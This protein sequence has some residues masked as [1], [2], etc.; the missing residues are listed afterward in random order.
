MGTSDPARFPEFEAIRNISVL[1]G[2]KSAQGVSDVLSSVHAGILTSEFE[3]M[4][5]SVLETLGAG[6]PV[7]AVHLPQLESVIKDGTSG[8]LIARST[9]EDEMA[10][11]LAE[12]FVDIRAR[13]ASGAVTP[14]GVAAQVGDFTP[15]KQ[16]AKIY[17]N[18]RELQRR[19]YGA[20]GPT[21]FAA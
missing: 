1:H 19:R 3:G 17:E 5:F 7:C 12:A 10:V 11:R 9:D 16:L 20:R 18:H 13:I 2:F 21:S 8:R 15:E 14:E 6:R 4:P